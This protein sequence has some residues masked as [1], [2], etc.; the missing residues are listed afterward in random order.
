MIVDIL[1]IDVLEYVISRPLSFA[2]I[3]D[4]DLSSTR[5]IR[6]LTPGMHLLD[7]ARN[8]DRELVEQAQRIA[9]EKSA[10]PN[11]IR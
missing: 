11:S 3:F 7:I 4:D 6:R 1:M 8:H 10:S 9:Q 2:R 5:R